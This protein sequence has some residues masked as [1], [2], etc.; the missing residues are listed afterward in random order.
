MLTFRHGDAAGHRVDKG[1]LVDGRGDG[2]LTHTDSLEK[3]NNI[4]DVLLQN[5]ILNDVQSQ[6]YLK[7]NFSFRDN[8]TAFISRDGIIIM[9]YHIIISSSSSYITAFECTCVHK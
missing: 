8:L 7:N 6:K 5:I 2:L 4:I 1:Y 9:V 3:R